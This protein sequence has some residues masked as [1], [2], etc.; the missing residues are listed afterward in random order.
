MNTTQPDSYNNNH[1]QQTMISDRG[2]DGCRTNRR[3]TPSTT[4][5]TYSRPGRP[6]HASFQEFVAGFSLYCACIFLPSLP[7]YF[8][9]F[10]VQVKSWTKSVG[11][12]LLW[13]IWVVWKFSVLIMERW[14]WIVDPFGKSGN[15]EDGEATG[16][17]TRKGRR[18]RI[19]L[20]LRNY[21]SST[22]TASLWGE[23][24]KQHMKGAGSPLSASAASSVSSAYT[25]GFGWSSS[26]HPSVTMIL[27]DIQTLTIL[28]VALAIIRV[29]FVHILVPEYLAPRRLE[30]LTRCKS[31]HLLSS[32][33]Y[34]F[35]GLVEWQS[36]A[37]RQ[38]DGKGN[39]A[40]RGSSGWYNR[41]LMSVSFRWYRLR[42]SIRRAL[43]H[44]PS[45]RYEDI[46][47]KTFIISSSPLR[48][49]NSIPNPAQDLF[50]APRHATAMFR[51]LYTSTSC[52]SAYYLFHN[53]VFWPRQLFGKH[54]HSSTMACWD[55]SGSVVAL[56]S[57]D[58]DYDNTNAALK[59]F[60]L[61]QAAYQ[62]H[63]LCFHMVSMGL[64]LLYGGGE[65]D[66][67][68]YGL[69][70]IFAEKRIRQSRQQFEQ[71]SRQQRQQAK[72]MRLLSMK[73]SMQSYVRPMLEHFIVLALLVGA[74]LFS[75]L[76]R[77]GA[78]GIFTLELSSVF[79][80]LLQVCIY[81]PEKSWWSQPRVVIF[82]HRFLTIPAF[83]YC[84]FFVLP[85]VVWYSA[86]FES[87]EWLDQIEKVFTRGWGQQIYFAFNSLLCLIFAL[88][89]VLF[90]RLLYH[91]HLRQIVRKQSEENV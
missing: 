49:S 50:S 35:G 53:A 12:C 71:L 70:N 2:R 68:F 79:L 25:W 37:R 27:R 15:S 73:T 16:M 86:A 61:A 6:K 44:E 84:R 4:D 57:L 91:P 52:F 28:A 30:A 59:Y 78:L 23:F 43:G 7:R 24:N 11:E 63:S 54:A 33:S 82:V 42:P 76:R 88:N 90:R 81:A 46:S 8:Y 64:L 74:Y 14:G 87:Q 21:L 40:D 69:R 3:T 85:F 18:R 72:S 13:Y 47:S 55:L 80:Q 34:R 9:L 31:S 75:G 77:V 26:A 51:L 38:I 58:E 17:V 65:N 41:V 5:T 32:S 29:W 60:F 67:S 89:L 48:R 22:S 83:I 39:D 45:A 10:C 36:V 66:R 62:L 1:Q 20:F 19:R 56:G